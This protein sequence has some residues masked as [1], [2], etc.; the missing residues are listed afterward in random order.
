MVRSIFDQSVSHS[1]ILLAQAS[2]AQCR[3]YLDEQI[4]FQCTNKM[5]MAIYNLPHLC[6]LSK[7]S[8]SIER[9]RQ[10]L[11]CLTEKHAIL[12]TSVVLDPTT[13]HL[14]QYVQSNSIH[15]WFSF[16]ISIID[17]DDEIKTI[18][19]DELTNRTYFDIAH[20]RVFRCHIVR[21]CSS[22]I[23]NT[24]LL[25]IGDWIIFN[26]HHMAFDGESQEIFFNDLQRFYAVQ[27]Q[28]E[29]NTKRNILQYID[30][31]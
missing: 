20:G 14:I 25:S 15:D 5:T 23:D 12:R 1:F 10:T 29:D 2:F 27:H 17:N 22:M 8:V 26:F 24:D 19:H 16:E 21:Q 13:G 11:R 3:I 7:A 31:K 9:L 28:L 30:C 18:F 6:R 4:R